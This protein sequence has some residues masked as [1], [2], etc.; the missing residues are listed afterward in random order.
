VTAKFRCRRIHPA[1]DGALGTTGVWC[2]SQ[3]P[4]LAMTGECG[5]SQV[6]AVVIAIII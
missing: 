2:Y 6:I 1:V 5:C 4:A 3:M